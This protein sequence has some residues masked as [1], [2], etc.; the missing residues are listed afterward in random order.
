[1]CLGIPGQ[2]VSIKDEDNYLATVDVAGVKRDVNIAC[3]VSE[4]YPPAACVGDWVLVHAGFAM[5]HIDEDE[6]QRNLELLGQLGD[7]QN[8]LDVIESSGS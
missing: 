1:M 5:S 7:I 8:E 6:A 3:V 2:I 4:A